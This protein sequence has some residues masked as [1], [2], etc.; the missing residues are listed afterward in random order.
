MANVRRDFLNQC[1][2][3]LLLM[4]KVI[5]IT[6]GGTLMRLLKKKDSNVLM[7]LWYRTTKDLSEK[8]RAHINVEWC[9]QSRCIKYLFK[10]I[11]KGQDRVLATIQKKKK[12][13]DQATAGSS[14]EAHIEKE[15]DEIKSFFDCRYHLQFLYI[16]REWYLVFN[17]GP[18]LFFNY[19]QLSSYKVLVYRLYGSRYVSACEAAWRILAYPIHYRSVPVEKLNFHLEGEQNVMYQDDDD[20]EEILNRPKQ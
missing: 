11:N 2:K 18:A 19:L 16:R 15:E 20:V 3:E 9:N 13:G 12:Q 8:Y 7:D 5:R 1:V 10:Y 17:H 14:G 6:E 4:N